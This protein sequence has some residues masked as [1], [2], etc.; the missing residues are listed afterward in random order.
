MDRPIGR[1]RHVSATVSCSDLSMHSLVSP[2][3]STAAA[4]EFIL[5]ARRYAS[6]VLAMTSCPSSRCSSEMPGPTEPP[7]SGTE[8]FFYLSHTVLYGNT[9]IAKSNDTSLWNFVPK[10]GLKNLATILWSPM[11]PDVKPVLRT[12]TAQSQPTAHCVCD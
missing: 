3:N 1:Y 4:R 6:A 10:S 5:P 12:N 9:G 2:R 7:F 11:S 8:A